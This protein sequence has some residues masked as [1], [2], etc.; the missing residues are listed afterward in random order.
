VVIFASAAISIDVGVMYA[1]RR[2]L[3][4]GAD[5]G[6]FAI[7]AQCNKTGTCPA[8][9][10]VLTSGSAVATATSYA[11]LNDDADGVANAAVCGVGGTGWPS[12]PAPSPG[13]LTNAPLP[14]AGTNYVR[15]TS[16]TQAVQSDGS[17][18]GFL[19]PVIAGALPGFQ[20]STIRAQATVAWGGTKTSSSV[21]PF[22]MSGCEW[23]ALKS[24]G[25]Y[26]PQ[27]PLPLASPVYPNPPGIPWSYESQ[28]ETHGNTDCTFNPSGQTGM[29]SQLSGDFGWLS[30][31]NTTT[32]APAL[33]TDANGVMT[34]DNK[35]GAAESCVK[36]WLNDN[37]GKVVDMPIFTE[38]TP[39]NTP[40]KVSGWVPFFLTGYNIPSKADHYKPRPTTAP[41]PSCLVG[42]SSIR[43]LTGFMVTMPPSDG[44]VVGMNFGLAANPR[45]L[46]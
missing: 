30:V 35:N 2:K 20:Q 7:A 18:A 44:P 9:G 14:P 26:A 25:G 23:Q 5:A 15:V 41:L 6:A 42:N 43:C 40:F 45:L 24:S 31:A 8:L 39:N 27:P 1:E 37:L 36:N 10:S 17:S 3:Q 34:V 33:A 32:C 29:G 12:C 28:V 46:G 11:G 22:I 13:D 16:S 21:L 19:P 38:N 4:S